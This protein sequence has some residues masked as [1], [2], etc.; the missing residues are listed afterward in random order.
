MRGGEGEHWKPTDTTEERDD[1]KE[2]EEEDEV[3]VSVTL[4]EM[5][6]WRQWP[7]ST[8]TSAT[9]GGVGEDSAQVDEADEF[10]GGHLRGIG[11]GLHMAHRPGGRDLKGHRRA[12]HADEGEGETRGG[13]RG[14]MRSGEGGWGRDC[15]GGRRGRRVRVRVGVGVDR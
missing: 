12:A 7:S 2:E 4:S 15:A 1:E 9:V 8:P 3:V 6:A 5:C 14:R 11:D 10:I 13:R